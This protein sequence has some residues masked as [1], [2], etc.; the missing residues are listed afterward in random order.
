MKLLKEMLLPMMLIG[1]ISPNP[2]QKAS[3]IKGVMPAN[4]YRRRKILMRSQGKSRN[5]NHKF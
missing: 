5:I 4:K 1:N 2:K 3:F